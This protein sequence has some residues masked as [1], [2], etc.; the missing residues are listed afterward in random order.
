MIAKIRRAVPEDVFDLAPRVR[1]VDREEIFAGWGIDPETGLR[2]S[3]ALSSHAW[4]GEIDGQLACLFGVAPYS[5]LTG[6][7]LPWFVASDEIE[8][9]Q[10]L[11]LRRC[12]PVVKRM[13]AI[14]PHLSNWVDARN[15]TAINWL[16]WLGFALD[17]PQPWGYLQLPFHR[18]EMKRA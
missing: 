3:V 6:E 5:I 12:G 18:F 17:D 14:Y 7:G 8:N 15:T 11:F 4:A 2:V 13:A 10:M 1:E 16:E 9:N